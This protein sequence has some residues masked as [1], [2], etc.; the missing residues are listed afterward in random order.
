[1]RVYVEPTGRRIQPFDDPVGDTPVCNRPLRAWQAEAFSSAGL[2]RVDRLEPP[3]LVVPD[4]LLASGDALR[5]FVTRAGGRDAVLVLKHSRFG[6]FTTPVQPRVTETADGW[7][8]E[9]VRFHAGA[10][11]GASAPPMDV[12]V[13]PAEKIF[14]VAVPKQYAGTDKVALAIPRRPVLELHHWVHILWA[15]Q[16]MGGVELLNTPK[17][18]LGL[19]VATAL[20]R[21]R[22][23]N[24]W[25]VL[26]KLNRIGRGCDIHPTALVEGCIL[27]NNVKV[28]PYAR[29]LFSHF[30]DGAHVMAGAYVEMCVLGPEALV[31]EQTV[32]RLSVLY[33]E[34][35]ASQYLMQ[36]CVFGREATTT[37]G[38]GTFDMNFERD[39]RV[40]LDGKLYSTGTRYLGAAFGHRC[41]VGA[42]F[43][44]AA[45]RAVPNDYLL[46]RDP[47]QIVSDLPENLTDAGPLNASARKLRPIK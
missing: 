35:V 13:D 4:T 34:A 23:M 18:K 29:L 36:Q 28:G 11:A 26:G 31:T 5:D 45:G 3:C 21:A 6:E 1:M 16:L 2:Q 44:L 20:V 42:G 33:P 14:Q 47:N 19:Q 40:K 46:V 37:A 17:W 24:R 22:S 43:W 27:G 8:F 25:K 30:D 32:L 10:G 15:N 38:A 39:I 12:V 7:R 9:S 41:R